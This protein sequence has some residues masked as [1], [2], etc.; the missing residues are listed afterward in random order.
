MNEIT[1]RFLIYCEYLKSEGEIKNAAQFAKTIGISTSLMTEILKERSNVGLMPIQKIVQ[2]YGANPE[3][4]L[5]G[6]GDM[7]KAEATPDEEL[8]AQVDAAHDDLLD[9]AHDVSVAEARAA[10]LER[11]LLERDKQVS[12][13]QKEVLSLRDEKEKD[14]QLLQSK[15][16]IIKSNEALL[17]SK[18]KI[19]TLLE[20]QQ[21][22]Q[23]VATYATEQG[24]VGREGAS[25]A[26]KRKLAKDSAL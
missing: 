19:I 22:H 12:E 4:L 10:A 9:A 21:H 2:L 23:Q 7:I 17:H 16:E 6:N 11:Q 20:Q 18:D 15:D 25:R 26:E 14:R 8:C 13:L 3:W 24:L 1:G 5:T